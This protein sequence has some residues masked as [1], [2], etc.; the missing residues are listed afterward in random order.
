MGKPALKRQLADNE[1]KAVHNRLRVSPIKLNVVCKAIRGMKAADA[2]VQLEFM[3]KR[4][5]REVK[6]CVQSA[7]A[8]AENNHNLDIDSLV[9]KEAYVG[10]SLVMKR[11]RARARGRGAR[12]MKPFSNLTIVLKEQE[13]TK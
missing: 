1:S 3:S 2:V 7:I 8:N 6:K 5:A 13:E 4:V 12:I 9:I 11:F 10:K